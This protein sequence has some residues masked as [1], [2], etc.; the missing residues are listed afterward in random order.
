MGAAV[1]ALLAALSPGDSPGTW[2]TIAFIVA[3]QDTGHK[4][5][6][7]YK[8]WQYENIKYKYTKI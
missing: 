1:Q 3:K 4:G 6:L 5:K 2:N 8:M 7:K